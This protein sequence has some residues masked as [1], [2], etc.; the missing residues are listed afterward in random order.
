MYCPSCGLNINDEE[1][2]ICGWKKKGKYRPSDDGIDHSKICAY[3]YRGE[4]CQRLGTIS[5]G[6]RGEGPWYCS[7]HYFGRDVR[8]GTAKKDWRDELI[9]SKITQDMYRQPGE[10]KSA[11]NERMMQM[12]K[13]TIGKM[14]TLPYDKNKKLSEDEEERLAIQDDY[15]NVPF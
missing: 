9:D 8:A 15:T 6:T 3:T 10:S 7:D 13:A 12:V 14:T 4:K 11:Y 5:G 2:C 1:S